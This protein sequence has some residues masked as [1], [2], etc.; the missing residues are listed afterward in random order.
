MIKRIAFLL[1]IF[2]VSLLLVKNIVFSIII[3]VIIIFIVPHYIKAQKSKQYLQ[4]F[5]AE[6][7]DGFDL[8]ANSIRAGNTFIQAINVL[9]SETSGPLAKEFKTVLQEN[10][11]G[12]PIDESLSKMQERVKNEELTLAITAVLVT[13]ESGG[14]I[15]EILKKISVTI[16]ER[17]RLR[18]RIDTLTAQSRL[19]GIV[20]G[21]LPFLLVFTIYLIDPNLISPMFNTT[22]GVTL[23]CIAIIMEILGAFFI[24][25]I[26]EIEI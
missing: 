12:I 3:S 8:I 17:Q 2:L 6:L 19:S 13:K 15:A 25:K 1:I 10:K 24:K 11:L 26:V 9:T 16:R 4:K 21:L 20:V 18:A 14:N 5:D 7:A 22:L 23:L